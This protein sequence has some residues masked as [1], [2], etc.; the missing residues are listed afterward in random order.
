[1]FPAPMTFFMAKLPAA[2]HVFL[3]LVAFMWFIFCFLDLALC[4]FV[5]HL[6]IL[7]KSA[8]TMANKQLGTLTFQWKLKLKNN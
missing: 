6:K 8:L 2:A 7:K 4:F 5:T 1:M 3:V